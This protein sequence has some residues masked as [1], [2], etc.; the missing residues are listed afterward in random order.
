MPGKPKQSTVNNEQNIRKIVQEE[1]AEELEEKRAIQQYEGND[2]NV[3]IPSGNI[4]SATNNFFDLL[5]P[6]TQVA[7][8]RADTG[9]PGGAYGFRIGDEINLK[10]VKIR[11]MVYMTDLTSA[12]QENTR[13]GVRV[14]ILKQKDKDSYAGFRADAHTNRLLLDTVGAS[15]YQGPG[16][17]NGSPLDLRRDI[18]RNEFAVRY[19]KTFYLSRD[20]IS[21]TSNT[22]KFATSSRDSLKFFEHDLTFG[23]GKKLT[24][25]DGASDTPNNFP[26]LLVVGPAGMVDPTTSITN[27]LV[28]LSVSSTAIY[29]DA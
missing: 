14:M 19:D 17:F 26:Y 22:N 1:L 18:N 16:Q 13:V 2:V 24:F 4:G 12:Q 29:T 11:G 21:G 10:K 3:V 28:K 27:G 8:S 9:A 20:F 6:I 23:N 15:G 25:T 7:N 5:P